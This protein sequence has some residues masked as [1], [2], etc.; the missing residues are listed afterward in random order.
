MKI[1][2]KQLVLSLELSKKFRITKKQAVRL[3]LNFCHTFLISQANFDFR[4]YY[5]D[6][7]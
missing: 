5:I 7:F 4:P 1:K 2:V 3:Y 6:K